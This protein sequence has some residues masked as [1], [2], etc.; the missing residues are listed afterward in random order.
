MEHRKNKLLLIAILLWFSGAV[1]QDNYFAEVEVKKN[2]NLSTKWDYAVL[3]SWKQ[4]YHQEGWTRVGL[5][6]TVK[7]SY[8]QW[9]VYGGLN[10]N[11]TFDKKAAN[12][13]EFRPWLGLGLDNTV[14]KTLSFSQLF[15][16]EW[17]NLVFA[18]KEYNKVTTRYRYLIKP[19]YDFKKNWSIFTGYEWYILPNK[20]LAT[21]FINSNEWSAGISKKISAY[22]FSLKYTKE[23]FNKEYQPDTKD[24]NTF[25]LTVVF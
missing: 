11:I 5:N 18:N 14:Y 13:W 7:R 20:N 16:F 2:L 1:A 6:A 24:G 22:T 9:S 19:K 25:T 12:Y 4:F 15:K 17:R 10:S 8:N 23:K 21:R 3:G